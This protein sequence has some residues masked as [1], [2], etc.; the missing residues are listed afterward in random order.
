M[1]PT[2]RK[3]LKII[4][5]P[6]PTVELRLV[7]RAVQQFHRIRKGWNWEQPELIAI[8]ETGM[9]HPDSSARGFSYKVAGYALKEGH[10][11]Y[12]DLLVKAAADESE[13]KLVKQIESLLK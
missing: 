9:N 1:R 11:L 7:I 5:L 12:R 4:D 3:T 10:N 6:P 13:P 2:A 8:L